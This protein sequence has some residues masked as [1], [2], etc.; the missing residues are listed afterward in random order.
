ME[1]IF[2]ALPVGNM[3]VPNIT[4][5]K[6][7]GIGRVYRWRIA[8]T[9]D[10]ELKETGRHYWTLCLSMISAMKIL[11]QLFLICAMNL[12]LTNPVPQNEWN[13]LGK[14][15]KALGMINPIGDGDVPTAP[16]T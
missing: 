14:I 12:P 16:I 15:V 11:R 6:T 4:S 10:M 8:R 3:Y 1:E 9:L 13:F 2:L 5:D 7:T